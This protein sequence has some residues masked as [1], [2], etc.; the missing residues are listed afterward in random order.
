MIT[1]VRLGMLLAGAWI[2]SPAMGTEVGFGAS[3]GV[4]SLEMGLMLGNTQFQ[5]ARGAD[6]SVNAYISPAKLPLA[7]SASV[8]HQ[9]YELNKTIQYFD[10]IEVTEADLGVEFLPQGGKARPMI[11]L[12]YTLYGNAVATTNGTSAGSLSGVPV[13]Q[14][15]ASAWKMNV[16]GTH[17]SVGTQIEAGKGAL[18]S[19]GLDFGQ[20]QAKIKQVSLGGADQTAVIKGEGLDHFRMQSTAVLIGGE[21]AI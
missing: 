14:N 1:R 12:G 13:A 5:E 3:A 21:V 7:I 19:L 2:A 16:G 10:H 11:R 9:S 17:F 20:T 15:G 4:R 18:L 6:A 8:D